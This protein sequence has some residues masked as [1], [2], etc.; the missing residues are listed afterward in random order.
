MSVKLNL[1]YS[2]S[3]KWKKDTQMINTIVPTNSFPKNNLAPPLRKAGPIKHW[4]KQLIPEDNRTFSKSVMHYFDTPGNTVN[5]RNSPDNCISC[6]DNGNS[7]FYNIYIAGISET[8]QPSYPDATSNDYDT[9]NNTC[10][11]CNPEAHV[12]KTARTK[13]DK[14]Y[15][16]DSRAY[17]KSRC[18]TYDE[19]IVLSKLTDNPNRYIDTNGIAIPPSNSVNGSQ[20]FNTNCYNNQC[21]DN[22]NTIGT[23]IYKPNNRQF[24]QQGAASSSARIAKLKYETITKNGSSF[25]SAL[26]ASAANAGRYMGTTEAPYFIKSKYQQPLCHIR[27]GISVKYNTNCRS[28]VINP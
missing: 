10:R 13:M 25:K 7:N 4:R 21:G 1:I 20:V 22:T 12:I 6:D 19:N 2:N 16:T 23:T 8:A 5:L 14:N 11:A 15:Y 9:V 18:K 26:G 27:N 24:A 3:I 28:L 17:L